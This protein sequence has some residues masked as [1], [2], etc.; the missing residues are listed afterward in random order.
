[1]VSLP[2]A[3]EFNELVSM[4]LKLIRGVW[5]LH[6]VDYLTRFSAVHP[7]KSKTAK[8]VMKKFMLIWISF[9]GPPKKILSDNRGEFNSHSWDAFC[10]AFNVLH[11]TTA[12]E[13]PFSNGICERHNA[14]VGEMTEKIID[15]VKCSIHIA[16]MWAVHAKNSLINIFGFSPYQ[17]VLGR[18]P[19]IP[20]NSA[21][22]LPALSD[23]SASQL[24][25]DHLNSLRIS[26]QAYIEAEYSNRV[27]R[28][29]RGKVFTGTHQKFCVGDTVY[30][31]RLDQ[32]SWH[33]PGKVITQDGTQVLI[34]TGSGT[35]IKVHP[36]K[37][38][39]KGGGQWV[40]FCET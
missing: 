29:L 33:G 11:K 39:L 40:F 1:M 2:L 19:N 5:L 16:L 27:T 13:A 30:Y 20:G 6:C 18:N 14:L 35:L 36:C 15:D 34:K 7:L 12:A 21:N 3:T 31:K 25:A 26:R 28:A 22:K 9:F 17:L 24:V 4:D 32:K 23:Q 38:I 37:V 8:E 10:E